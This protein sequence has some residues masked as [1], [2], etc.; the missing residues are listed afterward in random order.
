[1]SEEEWVGQRRPGEQESSK[2][3]GMGRQE[4]GARLSGAVW[5]T[6]ETFPILSGQWWEGG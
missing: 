2:V 6:V 4:N 1:M 5:T 3:W